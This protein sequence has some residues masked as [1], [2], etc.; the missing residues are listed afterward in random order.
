MIMATPLAIITE[1]TGV[2]L[3]PSQQLTIPF[4]SI[5]QAQYPPRTMMATPI[6]I[7]KMETMSFMDGSLVGVMK[8]LYGL[9]VVVN[10]LLASP[11]DKTTIAT[12]LMRLARG[13]TT[14]RKILNVDMGLRILDA[15]TGEVAHGD[16]F[17]GGYVL[18]YKPVFNLSRPCFLLLTFHH[19]MIIINMI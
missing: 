2:T 5:V 10:H 1:A 13:T 6:R 9:L 14:L 4:M 7:Q 12:L 18:E 11:T 8:G 15:E 3:A 19:I 16:S 17:V